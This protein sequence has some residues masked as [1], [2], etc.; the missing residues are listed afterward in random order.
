M[1]LKDHPPYELRK[2]DSFLYTREVKK[3]FGVLDD[4]IIW[5]KLN[6]E[7]E[8]GWQLVQ[9]CTDQAPGRYVFFFDSERDCVAFTLRWS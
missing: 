7:K 1:L 6:L 4:I 5:A 3:P 2:G 9:T 8:W